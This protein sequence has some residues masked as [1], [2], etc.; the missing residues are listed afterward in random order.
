MIDRSFV[1]LREV[2]LGYSLPA[3]YLK[4]KLIKA[5][6]FSLVGRNLLYFAKRKDMDVDQFA[7]GYNAADKSL[8]GS[9]ANQG[10]SSVTGRRFGFN[11]NLSF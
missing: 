3:K 10:L 4:G 9:S 1:K 11:I 6:S 8:S 2:L 7:A 5:A